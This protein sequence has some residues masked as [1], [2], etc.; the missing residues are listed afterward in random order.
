[1]RFTT[2]TKAVRLSAH[3]LFPLQVVENPRRLFKRLLYDIGGAI[4]LWKVYNIEPL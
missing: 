1:L 4:S 2:E 3:V